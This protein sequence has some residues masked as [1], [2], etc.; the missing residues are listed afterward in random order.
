MGRTRHDARGDEFG[1]I[2][3]LLIK[4]IKT[5]KLTLRK[6]MVLTPTPVLA[7]HVD[8]LVSRVTN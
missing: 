3:D 4:A 8:G 2:S 5:N 6:R 7:P 1:A